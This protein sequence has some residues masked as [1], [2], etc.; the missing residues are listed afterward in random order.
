VR[1]VPRGTMGLSGPK[2]G[3]RLAVPEHLGVT[4]SASVPVSELVAAAPERFRHS[5][6]FDPPQT[7]S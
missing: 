1:G 6:T 4:P 3:P 2:T 5:A 7:V